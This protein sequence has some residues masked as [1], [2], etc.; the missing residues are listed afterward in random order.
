MIKD[1]DDR[2]NARN[3]DILT[4]VKAANQ[5]TDYETLIEEPHNENEEDRLIK[6][7]DQKEVLEA[8]RWLAEENEKDQTKVEKALIIEQ[9][10]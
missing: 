4:R 6:E 5:L 10:D 8:M 3:R 9:D 7:I 2:N 1:C